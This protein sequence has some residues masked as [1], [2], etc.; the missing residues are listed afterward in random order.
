MS[1]ATDS[2]TATPDPA[3]IA[4]ESAVERALAAAIEDAGR[5]GDLLDVLRRARLWLPLPGGGSAA[6]KGTAV[7]L[8]TVCYLG[9]E[10]V[11]AYSSAQLMRQ[12]AGPASTIGS[13]DPA[14]P[15]SAAGP[16]ETVPHVVVRAADLARLLPPSVGIAL[17]AGASESVPVYPQGVSY[18]AAQ[19]G[20]NELDRISVGP[21]PIRPDGLLADIAAGLMQIAQVRDASAAWLSVQFAGEG[22]LISV[23]LDDP[24][25]A[26][27]RDFAVGAIE[28]AAWQ[29]A[30]QDAGFPI[31]VTFPGESEPDHIDEWISA[32]ATPFYRR[33]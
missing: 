3:D 29:A 15:A 12:L 16:A 17:N 6:I 14:E 33:A 2:N 28:R 1:I 5:I 25:E 26:A 7:T 24:T 27:A 21:L 31:D 13:A 4:P 19:D 30:A 23:T 20:G 18:L 10:F 32:F 11:P 8:P 9:S 22:L